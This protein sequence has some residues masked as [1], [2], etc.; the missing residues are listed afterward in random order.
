MN[1]K[2]G[3]GGN[4]SDDVCVVG[5]WLKTLVIKGFRLCVIKNKA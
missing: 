4:Q 2:V 5:M 1:Y 3:V